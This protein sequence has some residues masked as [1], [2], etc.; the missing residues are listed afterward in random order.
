[1]QQGQQGQRPRVSVLRDGPAREVSRVG[2]P[3]EDGRAGAGLLT[4][5]VWD[6]MMISASPAALAA[7]G[8]LPAGLARALALIDAG[9]AM[10][11][12]A[13]DGG[14]RAVP[15][16]G[17]IHPY[18]CYVIVADDGPA[19][20]ATD[21]VRR[22]V[23]PRATGER[24]SGPLARV[25]L[26]V[27]RHGGALVV[28]V[29]RPWLSM[30]KY[31]DRGYLYTQLDTAHLAVNLLGLAAD[32]P[33]AGEGSGAGLG[34]V[35][36][37]VTG[38]ITG[39]IT[40][41]GSGAA[42]GPARGPAAE[43]RLRLHRAPL[44]EMLGAEAGCREIH[45]VL[46]AGPGSGPAPGWTVYE[47][48]PAG[49]ARGADDLSW[50]ERACW[51]SLHPVV[52]E[53]PD[54]APHGLLSPPA[55]LLPPGT[56][57]PADGAARLAGR[58]RTLS[59][60][61]RS[62]KAFRSAAVDSA[63]LG[64]ALAAA[65]TPLATDLPAESDLHVTLLARSVDGLEPGAYRLTADGRRAGAQPRPTDADL[66][67]ACMHQD[68]LGGAAAVVLFHTR[69]D[70]LLGRP[71]AAMREALFRA[72][73]IGQL[74]YLGATDAGIGVTGVGGFDTGRWQ[75]LGCVPDDHELLYLV[76]LGA[77]TGPGV[78]WDR[79]QTAYAQGER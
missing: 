57:L 54:R 25:G 4:L 77:D 60:S 22:R 35:R 44:A 10:V 51:Q 32:R 69:R 59:G 72:G 7:A 68:H 39:S 6:R 11:D 14:A 56:R 23:F 18:E 30:R 28:L 33:A 75:S 1:M 50:M 29:T 5:D 3:P 58:W 19:L 66:V 2:A 63:V 79:L 43:L 76:L 34:P 48:G 36:D 71:P 21:A 62:T 16:A 41:S 47:E 8:G 70:A 45:S 24:V 73:A 53:D 38:S 13:K 42:Q 15:S 52:E 78:K 20:Y 64:Q 31:G 74:L 46:V 65:R 9:F 40:G 27:P 55:P 17:A 61:R 26:E 67:R 37:S 12:P 49:P